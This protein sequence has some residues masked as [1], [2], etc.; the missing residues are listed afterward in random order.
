MTT[1]IDLFITQ[2][3]I[4]VVFFF[5][6][7]DILR[8]PA[9]AKKNFQGYFL[10]GSSGVLV[11]IATVVTMAVEILRSGGSSGLPA[12]W[13]IFYFYLTFVCLLGLVDDVLGDRKSTGLR[14]HFRE[15]TRGHFTS[16]A[17]KAIGGLMIAIVVAGSLEKRYVLEFLLDVGVMAL[18]LNAFNSLDLRPGRAIKVFLVAAIA[19][20]AASWSPAG[21]FVWAVVIPPM[22]V[23]L[24]A[25]LRLQSMLGDAGSN[26]LGAVF[27]FVAVS[28]L[29]WK[30]NL[31]ILAVLVLF[32][33]YTETRSISELVMRV[34]WLRRL[35]E[36][37]LKRR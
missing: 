34:R 14:G 19:L 35:D 33:L 26:L 7:R 22:L 12:S 25:D 17:L 1:Y 30:A 24:W 28:T 36:L 9:T 6:L 13:L 15:L 16:G 11:P 8:A 29:N 32:H 21:W 3:V 23:L 2:L 5:P 27:G 31:V 20:M 37:G 10:A 4:S 18:S